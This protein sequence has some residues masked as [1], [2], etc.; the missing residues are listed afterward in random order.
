M[1]SVFQTPQHTST[2]RETTDI[3]PQAL[4]KELPIGV[5]TMGAQGEIRQV[6]PAALKLLGVSADQ[7][8]GKTP[9][10]PNWQVIQ[11]NGKPFALKLQ[12]APVKV[13]NVLVLLAN[14]KSLKNLILG[15]YRP[16]TGD[17]IWLSV[18]TAPQL[19]AENAVEEVVCTLSDIT[20]NKLGEA[21]TKIQQCFLSLGSDPDENINGLTALAGELLGGNWALYNRLHQGLICSWGQ[22]QTPPEFSSVGEPCDYIC[23]DVIQDGSNEACVIQDLQNTA[24]AETA[25]SVKHYQLQTY[26]GQAVKSGGES[27]GSLCVLY[28]N[29][30]V[31]TA[32]E[33]QLLGMIA[34]M[35]S[36]QEERKREAIVWSQNEAKWRSL[37]QNSSNLITILEADGTIRYTS[38]AV[39]R[40]L[41]Y[42]ATEL[43]GRKAFELIHPED[44]PLVG[45]SFQQVLQN[46]T[47]TFTFEFKCQHKDGSWRYI[48]STH[49]NLLVDSP[50]ARIVVNSRDITERKQAE[51]AL[52]ESE[53]Q[54][55]SYSQ[56]LEQALH[57]LQE[58]QTQLIQTEKMS[59]LGQLVAGVAHE[60]NNPVSFIYGNIPHATAYTKD[61]LQLI[62]LYRQ[63]YPQP[64]AE[65]ENA[66]AEIDLDFVLEDL[67]KLMD[68]MQIGA[69]RIRQIVLSLRNFSRLDKAAREA[70]D[71]HK[72][73]DNTLLL[74]QHRLK[75]K[76]ERPAI[77]VITEYSN[78]PLVDCYAGQLNQVFMNI[79]SNAIDALEEQMEDNS[80]SQ[81]ATK[82]Q[83]A[84][85]IRIR[86]EIQDDNQVVI[87]IADNGSGIPAEVQSRLFDPF[88]TTKPVGKGTGLGLSISYQIV[89]EKHGGQL[90]CVSNPGEGTEFVIELPLQ[91]ATEEGA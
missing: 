79:L 45:S 18:S 77:K 5:L 50:V 51:S 63:H 27:I 35:I 83:L 73:I 59:S 87:R 2:P 46:P 91:L 28:Q 4:V 43:I 52:R 25:P 54:L 14:R 20:Q 49:S 90:Q 47:E 88:F 23:Y 3:L 38:P 19:N 34:A 7:L 36:V 57:E 37:L 15:V 12:S 89:V 8:L 69:E 66:E 1:V 70:V 22:W 16:E 48:E 13:R 65:I 62:N 53:A 6:N 67:P 61:L 9:L 81:V 76:G 32:T 44:V 17:R 42:K 78:L 29:P 74:L 80:S 40:I 55:R 24:Y 68:S 21:L 26:I 75:A 56:Q 10:D 64:D 30:F 86:T 82:A 71:L 39:E 41:G 72:G 11:E 31:P 33:K 84:P 85:Q 58:T 60:I